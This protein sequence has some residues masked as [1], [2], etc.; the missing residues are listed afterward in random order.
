LLLPDVRADDG[1]RAAEAKR[2]QQSAEPVFH[3][4]L[5]EEC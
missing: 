3:R 4:M 1:R 5:P 2:E